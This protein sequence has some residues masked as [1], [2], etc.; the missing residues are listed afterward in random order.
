[1]RGTWPASAGAL[2]RRGRGRN[3]QVSS[4]PD[5][6]TE[7]ITQNR[8]FSLCCLALDAASQKRGFGA[9]L[10]EFTSR[11][12]SRSPSPS[13]SPVESTNLKDYRVSLEAVKVLLRVRAPLIRLAILCLSS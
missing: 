9:K 8:L 6:Q 3:C 4:E 2:R 5:A 10:T 12:I 11:V 1:M 7:F 13:P